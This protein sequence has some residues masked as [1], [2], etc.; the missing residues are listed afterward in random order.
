MSVRP[1]SDFIV[2]SITRQTTGVTRQGFGEALLLVDSLLLSDRVTTVTKGS[3]T[4]TLTGLGFTSSDAIYTAFSDY[5]AQAPSPNTGY[6]GSVSNTQQDIQI[7]AYDVLTTYTITIEDETGSTT[8]TSLA[9]GSRALAAAELATAIAA[10]SQN[11]TASDNVDVVEITADPVSAAF[12]SLGSV[13][14]G[15]GTISAT[16][17]GAIEDMDT[18][19]TNCLAANSDWFGIVG[20]DTLGRSLAQQKLIATWAESN[21]RLYLVA[22]ADDNCRDLTQVGDASTS[23]AGYCKTFALKNTSVIFHGSAATE[24]LDAGWFGR[25]LQADPGSI[26]WNHKNISSVTVDSD[27]T[28]NQRTNMGNKGC[29]W[30]ESVGGSNRTQLGYQKAQN[31]YG[32]YIDISR[33]VIW[34]KISMEEEQADLLLLLDKVPLTDPGIAATEA[35]IK[36]VL[37]QGKTNGLVASYTIDAPDAADVSAANKVARHLAGLDW[38]AILAGAINSMAVTGTVT[39]S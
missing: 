4:T 13:A 28:P 27:I 25:C 6:L 10:G 19:L 21:E 30:Y 15:A 36:K 35:R 2:I 23:I 17:S 26:N 3:W 14:A 18:A 8:Y 16:T 24:Y 33:G 22:S 31:G 12:S 32:D 7:T 34:L 5:F 20:V 39:T 29:S 1:L 11:V 37:E 9:A 38:T